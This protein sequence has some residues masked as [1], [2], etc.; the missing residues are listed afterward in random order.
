MIGHVARHAIT[1]LLGAIRTALKTIVERLPLEEGGVH[2][3]PYDVGFDQA[4]QRQRWLVDDDNG[5]TFLQHCA[6]VFGQTR[7]PVCRG[8]RIN[9]KGAYRQTVGGPAEAAEHCRA[10]LAML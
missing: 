4:I 5:P 10:V 6:A 1:S 3:I 2:V 9:D 8:C 7:R